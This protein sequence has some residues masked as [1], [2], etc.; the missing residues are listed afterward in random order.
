MVD[1]TEHSFSTK[2][3]G[4]FQAQCGV[5]NLFNDAANLACQNNTTQ[6]IDEENPELNAKK[7]SQC[8]ENMFQAFGSHGFNIKYYT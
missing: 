4:A 3:P 2:N 1:R 5:E 8:Y 6:L 7:Y